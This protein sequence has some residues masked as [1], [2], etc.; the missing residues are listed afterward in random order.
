MMDLSIWKERKAK[1]D[2]LMKKL[3]QWTAPLQRKMFYNVS[4]AI[5]NQTYHQINTLWNE[6]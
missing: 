6:R 4:I 1:Y 2:A 3:Y 5:I